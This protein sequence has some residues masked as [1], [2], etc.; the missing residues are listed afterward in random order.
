MD[1]LDSFLGRNGFMPHGYCISWTPELL[2]SMVGA[3]AVIA[4]AYFSIP[5]AIASFLRKRPASSMNWVPRL[6]IAFIFWCGVTHVMDIWTVWQPDYGAQALTKM[7]TAAISLVTAVGLWPLIPRA[8]KIPSVSQLQS[9]IKQLEGEIQKRRTA[10]DH[11]GELQQG[12]AVT[13]AS[14]EAGFIATDREGRVTRM[15]E[16]AERVTGRT[17]D[18]ARG[19]VLWDVLERADGSA[20]SASKSPVDAMIDQGI[21][22]NSGAQQLAVVAR[23]GTRTPIE[24]R[25]ALTR[26]DDGTVRGLALVFRDV[27]H[28]RRAEAALRESE[29]RLRFTLEAAQIGDWDLDLVGGQARRSLL[30]DRCFGY[31]R[32]QPSWS[33]ETFLSHVHPD[34]RALVVRRIEAGRASF[35]GWSGEYRVIWPDASVH[36]VRT[37]VTVQNEGG[38]ATH[39]LGIISDITQQKMDEAARLK[40]QELE[41]ENRQILEANRVKGQF[42]AN[43]SHELRTPLN[44]VIGFADLLQSGAVDADVAKR[45]VFLGHIGTSG[46][47]LLRLINDLLDLSKV[48]SGR[49]EFFPEPVD[50]APLVKD[51]I[52]TLGPASQARHIEVETE[53]DPALGK[54]VLDPSRM[55]QVLYNYLSNAIKFTPDRGHVTVRAR[56]EGA[57]R[58]RLE[59]ED[60]GIGIAPIDVPRL[61]TEFQQLDASASKRHQGTGLGLALTR[62]LVEAQGGSVGVRS[63]PG[64]GSVFHLVLGRVLTATQA[65]TDDIGLR[66]LD[67]SAT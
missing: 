23:D 19:H 53:I 28:L 15:N 42:L 25:A 44:A 66:P 46:R 33:Y 41:A 50:L 47:H 56:P 26:T 27:S 49:F 59:V 36:W 64:V 1:V 34:D 43:M 55:K 18:D 12:L 24:L 8:L 17:Q 4:T 11:L 38:K 35:K 32:M 16:V 63:V 61:F 30:H 45:R 14:V 7:V 10:E 5:L 65:S 62:R 3:D 60:T 13:L 57:T 40:A 31:D 21:D 20:Q 51:V 6:F 37:H 58:F 67:R 54:L 52:D 2:W 22:V 48:E 39:M 9:V 29:G